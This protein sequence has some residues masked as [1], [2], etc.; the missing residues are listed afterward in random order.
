MSEEVC[1][2]LTNNQLKSFKKAFN[3]YSRQNNGILKPEDLPKALKMVG[4]RPTDEEIQEM[5]EEIGTD[6]PIDIVEFTICIYYFLRAADTQEELINAFKIF[7]KKKQGKLP[8]ATIQQI[9]TSLKHPVSQPLIQELISQLDKDGSHMI[10]Y[11]EMIR[12]MR[13][14]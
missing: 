9:L 13:P 7:D 8:T 3:H 1:A 2:C 14:N 4:I 12:L 11:A 5:I 10:D 6:N